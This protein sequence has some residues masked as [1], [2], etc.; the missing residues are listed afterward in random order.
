MRGVGV[1]QTFFR[2]FARAFGEPVALRQYLIQRIQVQIFHAKGQQKNEKKRGQAVQHNS[3][4]V[5]QRLIHV[6]ENK[7]TTTTG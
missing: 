3:A 1:A 5:M 2:G 7:E 4:Q 6:E